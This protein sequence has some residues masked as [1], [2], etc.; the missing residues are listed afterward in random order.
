MKIDK[1]GKKGIEEGK[2]N[3]VDIQEEIAKI[4]R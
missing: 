3:I 4:E 1:V 2:H